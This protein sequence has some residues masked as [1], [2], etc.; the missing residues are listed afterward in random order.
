MAGGGTPGGR[1][2]W[3]IEDVRRLS[4][5]PD[6]GNDAHPT[7]G[8]CAVGARKFLVAWNIELD[9]TVLH[10]AREIARAIRESS[11][12]LPKVKALGLALPSKNRVQV[13]INLIDF[14]VTPLHVVFDAVEALCKNVAGSELIGLIPQAALDRSASH[15]L[16][17][18]NMRPELVLENALKRST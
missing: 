11:G 17:W 7:A 9:S 14:E 18:L 13:S 2:P 3:P 4:T 1:R 15:D 5:P 12:G 16:H 10:A 6:L 8:Y